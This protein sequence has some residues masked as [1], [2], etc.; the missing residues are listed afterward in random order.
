MGKGGGFEQRTTCS[1]CEYNMV[2]NMTG[3]PATYCAYKNKRSCVMVRN[4]PAPRHVTNEPRM[5]QEDL[6]IVVGNIM[7]GLGVQYVE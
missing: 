5:S 3:N 1:G 2:T 7:L 6:N 4:A